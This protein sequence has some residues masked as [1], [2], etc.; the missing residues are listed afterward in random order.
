MTQ[1]IHRMEHLI[2]FAY[3]APKKFKANVITRKYLNKY[4]LPRIESNLPEENSIEYKP[5]QGI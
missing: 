4:G 2:T 5:K 3:Q 1:F